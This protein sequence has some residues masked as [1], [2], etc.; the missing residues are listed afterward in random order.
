MAVDG[1][2]WGGFWAIF[3]IGKA[4]S[5]GQETGCDPPL[6]RQANFDR[7]VVG[8]GGHSGDHR[9]VGPSAVPP[10]LKGFARFDR[11]GEGGSPEP[12]FLRLDLDVHGPY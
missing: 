12:P 7:I 5:Q 8:N 2:E 6:L 4:Q 3:V 11:G 1:P 10:K 9:G